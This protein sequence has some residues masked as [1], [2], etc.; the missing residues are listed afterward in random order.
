MT[1]QEEGGLPDFIC[2]VA[3]AIKRSGKSTSQAIEIAVGR[4]RKW[5]SGAG[6][7]SAKTKAKAA[8]AIAS[9]D[10]K[11][12]SAK[13]DNVKATNSDHYELVYNGLFTPF[14][15]TA[16]DE[17]LLLASKFEDCTPSGVDRILTLSRD[18]KEHVSL[19][20]LAARKHGFL[21]DDDFAFPETRKYPIPDES[22]ARAAL[23][24]VMFQ[25]ND[26]DQKKVRAA[27]KRRFPNIDVGD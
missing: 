13:S 12:S 17:S 22:N 19:A 2:R 4:V 21:K 16:S 18:Q 23:S 3:R 9:W 27:V 10:K 5:A 15:F 8:A 1:V 14:T 26:E 11:R 24:R 25:G 20:T 7:V 6:G